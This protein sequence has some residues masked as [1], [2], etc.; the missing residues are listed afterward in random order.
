MVKIWYVYRQRRGKSNHRTWPLSKN[1]EIYW[2][3]HNP[4]ITG[5]RLSAVA[6]I[7]WAGPRRFQVRGPPDGI[8][9]NRNHN[10]IHRC[11]SPDQPE[12]TSFA[13][14]SYK[15]ITA[16][17]VG[18]LRSDRT[19]LYMELTARGCRAARMVHEPVPMQ[20]PGSLVSETPK[21]YLDRLAQSRWGSVPASNSAQPTQ[22]SEPIFSRILFTLFYW[23]E[24]V[25]LETCFGYGYVLRQ[26]STLVPRIF[27]SR[28]VQHQTQCSTGQRYLSPIQSVSG[29]PAPYKE[30]TTLPGAPASVSRLHSFEAL[31]A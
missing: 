2:T 10:L 20:S 31:T 15:R 25:H 14:A 30:K 29:K 23:P 13:R 7:T 12:P 27:K 18:P 19:S 11:M 6:L 24:A 21:P 28:P 5:L 9:F 17:I 3:C 16:Q 4:C 8:N 1:T 26:E 22:S